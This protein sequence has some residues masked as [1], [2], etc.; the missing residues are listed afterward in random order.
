MCSGV[1]V[2]RLTEFRCQSPSFVSPVSVFPNMC[3]TRDYVRRMNK[4]QQP[5]ETIDI[6][7]VASIAVNIL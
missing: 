5:T 3:V 2:V 7:V 1:A 6:Y 4:G